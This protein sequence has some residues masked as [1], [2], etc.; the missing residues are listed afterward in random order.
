MPR[1][2]DWDLTHTG[3]GEVFVLSYL[4]LSDISLVYLSVG[5]DR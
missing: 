2:P 5:K 1:S 4:S 3:L